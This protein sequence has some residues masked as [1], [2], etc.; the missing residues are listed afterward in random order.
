LDRVGLAHRAQAFPH[1]LSGGEQQRVSLVRALASRPRAV[2]LDEPFSGLDRD[3][4]WSLRETTLSTLR[5]AR[6]TAIFVTHDAEDAMVSA[7]QIVIVHAGKVIQAGA[8]RVVYDA[9]TS[10]RAALGLGPVNVWR[11]RAQ[12]GAAATP[13]GPFACPFADGAEVVVA[14]RPEA[15]T[16]KSGGAIAVMDRRPSG[17]M[18]QVMLAVGDQIWTAYVSVEDGL[19]GGA[20]TGGTV[21]LSCGERGVHVFCADA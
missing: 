1:Q 8:P 4:R 9:P 18:D 15:L 3:L 13:I 17:A 12:S 16:V 19:G 10:L 11:T 5:A 2:L 14:I 21:A 7:D 6:M 20:Q